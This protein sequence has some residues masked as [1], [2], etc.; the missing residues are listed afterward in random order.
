MSTVA[1]TSD[2]STQEQRQA[3][4][5]TEFQNS[6]GYMLRFCLKT[7]QQEVTYVLHF[8]PPL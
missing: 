2:P 8:C 3:I 6:Q 4:V 5:R 7:Q 1:H